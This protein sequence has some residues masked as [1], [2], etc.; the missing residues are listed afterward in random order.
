MS[1]AYLSLGSNLGDSR[2][3]LRAAAEAFRQDSRCNLLAQSSLY[4]TAPWGK[5]DQPDFLN[6]AL[7]LE[8]DLEPLA[9]LSF[10][11]SLEQ[12]A[13]RQRLEHWGTRTLDVDIIGIAG[14]TRAE[15]PLILPHPYYK[16]RLFVL[17]P[18]LEIA[19]NISVGPG[20]PGLAELEQ[21]CR[22][23]D[24]SQEENFTIICGSDEW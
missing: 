6:A 13:G 2:G 12:Q 7:I 5:T 22:A 17:R 3:Y 4:R 9:L 1:R 14:L 18:L 8:T 11:Q 24:S 21:L 20:E 23:K 19:G 10:C 16:E 15:Q